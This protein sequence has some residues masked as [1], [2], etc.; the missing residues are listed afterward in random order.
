MEKSLLI[1]VIRDMN[2]KFC[3]ILFSKVYKDKYIIKI[4][5]KLIN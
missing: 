3:F 5:N 1:N 2:Y 4:Y